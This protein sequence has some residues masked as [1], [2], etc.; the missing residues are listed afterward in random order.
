MMVGKLVDLN[1]RSNVYQSWDDSPFW[2]PIL[3]DEIANKVC[4]QVSD[5]FAING[6]DI[7]LETL[8]V[9]EE[10]YQGLRSYQLK[11]AT[12]TERSTKGLA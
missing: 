9:I 12:D 1:K 5:Y 2:F 10:N 7:G 4:E 6:T 3:W 11:F 8:N